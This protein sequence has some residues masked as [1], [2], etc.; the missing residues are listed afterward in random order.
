M[1]PCD[2]HERA[3]KVCE[4]QPGEMWEERGTFILTVTERAAA[5]RA[6][7]LASGCAARWA[8]GLELAREIRSFHRAANEPA[9]PAPDSCVH[10]SEHWPCDAERLA[11]HLE[12]KEG[13]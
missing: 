2:I 13:R 11:D 4:P 9:S 1:Q 3:A 6:D 10:C 5:I 8:K 12:E 7:C